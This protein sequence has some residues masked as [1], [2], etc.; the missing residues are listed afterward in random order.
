M[1]RLVNAGV[2]RETGGEQTPFV[3][4]SLTGNFYF[5]QSAGATYGAGLS[6]ADTP[7]SLPEGPSVSF[8]NFFQS[9]KKKREIEEKWG[10]WQQARQNDF[11]KV[12]QLDSDK[13]LSPGKRPTPGESF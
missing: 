2:Q 9:S 5:D 1:L 3:V 6:S 4:H 11:E 7:P 12:K 13:Y 10:S 8:D